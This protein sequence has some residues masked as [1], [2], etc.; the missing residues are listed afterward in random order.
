MDVV[1]FVWDVARGADPVRGELEGVVE[2]GRLGGGRLYAIGLHEFLGFLYSSGG[3][4]RQV[5][6]DLPRCECTVNGERVRTVARFRAALRVAGG[7][8]SFLHAMLPFVSQATMAVP[9]RLMH[10]AYEGAVIVDGR[11]PLR[12]EFDVSAVERCWSVRVMKRMRW[13]GGAEVE[14]S[15]LY[16][17]YGDAV[18]FYWMTQTDASSEAGGALG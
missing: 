5:D 7:C 12:V 8:E 17:S 15:V 18:M 13:L 2:V 6:V 11:G 16:E 14:M 9:L 10:A 4:A 3:M 1:R